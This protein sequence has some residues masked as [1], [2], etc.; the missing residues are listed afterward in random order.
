M[1]DIQNDTIIAFSELP[2]WCQKNLGRRISPSTIFRWK[3]RGCRGVKLATIL[4]GGQRCTSV[5]ALQSFFEATT[6]AQ[7]GQ[8]TASHISKVSGRTANNQGHDESVAFLKS[9][10]I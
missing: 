6:R 8:S 1:I 2:A 4:I 10:G 5:E 9:E 7:D 3:L